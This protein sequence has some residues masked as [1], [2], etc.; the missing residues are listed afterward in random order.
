[1][2]YG[3]CTSAM[4][5]KAENPRNFSKSSNKHIKND[6][7][8]GINPSQS[9]SIAYFIFYNFFHL[10]LSLRTILISYRV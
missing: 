8:S 5:L 10:M 3:P 1:M 2:I 6:K 7:N 9:C 4:F